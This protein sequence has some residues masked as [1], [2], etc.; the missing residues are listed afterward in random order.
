[1]SLSVP[2]L[3]RL[4][5][6]VVTGLASHGF[7]RVVLTNYQADPGHLRAIDGARRELSRRGR[8]QALVAGFEPGALPPTPMTNPRMRA[9]LRSPNP[10]AE[11]HAGELETAFMLATDRRL[12][13]ERIMRPAARSRTG[14]EAM[15][16]RGRLIA[17]QL[18]RAHG[19][20]PRS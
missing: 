5:V 10:A 15:A 18:V 12:V 3:R 14:R 20:R 8:A 4:I 9:L 13:R 1:V 19:N 6:E 17:E 11:W 2:T 7:R 16:L